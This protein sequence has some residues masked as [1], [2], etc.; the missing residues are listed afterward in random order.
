MNIEYKRLHEMRY[1]K[2][3][4]F[5]GEHDYG[6]IL[7]L[8]CYPG[9]FGRLLKEKYPQSNIYLADVMEPPS[10]ITDERVHFVKIE[11]L[12]ENRLPFPDGCFDLVINLEMIEHLYKPDN[13]LVEIHRVLKPGGTLV[14][15]T[16]NLASWVNRI[17]L[18]F[19]YFPRGM[20][21]SVKSTLAESRDFLRRPQA[22]SQG[23]AEFDYH[24]RLYTFG[25]LKLLLGV[26]GFSITKTKG[27]YGI[28]SPLAPSPVRIIHIIVEKF[29]PA[30]AQFILIKASAER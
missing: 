21:I 16:P 13:L 18:L 29:L 7:D 11:D 26:H 4:N 23:Q 24:V 25:A 27:I 3:L 5:L 6:D 22:E 19:G 12:N 10:P 15:S 20:D 28:K 8:G 9:E 2:T 1:R 30:M 17:L 14:L